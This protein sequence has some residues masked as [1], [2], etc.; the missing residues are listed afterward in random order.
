MKRLLFFFS[1]AVAVVCNVHA[2]RVNET[3]ARQVA[4]QFFSANSS[5]FA[6]PAAQSAIRLAYTAEN[7]RF[8]VFDCGARGG[9]VVVSGDDR[10]P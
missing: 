1:I 8:Y 5:R 9:F 3:V 7:E 10:L 2:A 6:A 4:N